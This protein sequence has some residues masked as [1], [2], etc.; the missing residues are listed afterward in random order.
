MKKYAAYYRVSKDSYE[1]G[2][3]LS[4]HLSFDGQKSIGEHFCRGAIEKEYYETKSAKNITERPVLKDAIDYCLKN[5]Y[6]LFVSKLDRL[7]RN[8][9]DVRAILKRLNNRVTFGDIPSEGE[10]DIFTIT[11]Y[12]AFAERERELISIRTRAALQQKIKREG[13][14]AFGNPN[15][16]EVGKLGT[17]AVMEK[18]R[19]NENSIKAFEVIKREKEK[20]TGLQ[21]IADMLNASTFVS[22]NGGK[23]H[24]I[25][26]TRIADKF[27]A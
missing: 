26:I 17:R 4:K 22:P 16:R 1:S 27:A 24:P 8:V 10:A 14:Y 12:A 15:I 2:R 19:M 3:S 9:D 23:F 13:Q 7:S 25:Q 21:A 11:I 6:W 5:G 18:A 20:G